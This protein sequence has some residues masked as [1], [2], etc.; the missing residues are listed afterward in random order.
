MKTHLFGSLV[1]VAGLLLTLIGGVAAQE[2]A[3]TEALPS[4]G[5]ELWKKNL[6]LGPNEWIYAEAVA[7]NGDVYIGGDVDTIA[8]MKT[9]RVAR[10]GADDQQ[11]HT[12][13]KSITWGRIYSLAISGDYLYVGGYFDAASDLDIHTNAIARWN[14]V[15]NTW[16]NVGG[17]GFSK[18]SG[19]PDVYALAVDGSGNVYAGGDFSSVNGIPAQNVAKWDGNTWSAVGSLGT[20]NEKVEALLW[21]GSTLI[22]GGN[23]ANLH[24][25][26]AWNGASWSSL[27]GGADKEVLALAA[28]SSFLY[29]GGSFS[30][31][32]NPNATTV[33]VHYIAMWTWSSG[34][35][36]LDMGG[37]FDG[38]DVDALAVGPDNMVYA[39]GRFHNSG[40]VTTSN[41][42]RWNNG[43]W[44]AVHAST[45]LAEGVY[46]N[47][48]ALTFSGQDLWI[49]GGFQTA[50]DFSTNY[51]VRWNLTDQQWFTPGG[52]TPN[53]PIY[54]VLV[55]YPYVYYGGEFNS[56]GGIRTSGVAR[57]NLLT[58]AW[59]TL[60]EGLS[61]CANFLCNG[62]VVNALAIFSS[63]LYVGGDFT[64][65]GGTAVHGLARFDLNTTTWYDVGGGVT[66]SGLF[67][68]AV[69]KSLYFAGGNLFVGGLFLKAGAVTVNNVAEWSG[70]NWSA[71]HD[72]GSGV[73][74]T[75]GF[76]Y[77][78]GMNQA[79]ANIY[80][81]GN[82][83][84]PAAKIA[85]WTGSNW[86]SVGTGT[87][88]NGAVNAVDYVGSNLFIG[89]DFTNAGGSSAN[90]LARLPGGSG[91][92]VAVGG[93]VDGPVRALADNL[94]ELVVG[95]DFTN[96]G[97]VP[98]K[99][100]V[101]WTGT[102]WKT[103][104][105]GMSGV[106]GSSHNPTVNAV[107]INGVY[108][109]LG[110]TFRTAGPFISDNIAIW[111][112]RVSYL[113]LVNR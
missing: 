21:H 26:A 50:G 10:W 59:S 52:N 47:V 85:R 35:Y 31:V 6:S 104:G 42:A 17:P 18:T 36:W 60:G 1:L 80:I 62:P 88:L 3:G 41:I 74:G 24:Y 79:N 82:F 53:G 57:Y 108:V 34:G 8:S 51:V 92:W 76:V 110:G 54:A 101:R 22:A 11:W 109:Y 15:T 86:S 96:A 46:G 112:G 58:N 28:D 84:S 29:V 43:S 23:F 68:T 7:P 70:G 55:I 48:Y 75:N 14:M 107:V 63:N 93:S 37:G 64:H 67:C 103:L 106:Q 44:E 56:A 49:G 2:D 40:S 19:S 5:D 89:G 99:H 111:G 33:C 45:S 98:A 95:G 71:L 27:G 66:C 69:V 4:G 39:G 73:T 72:N 25:I 16:S 13:G 94:S 102:L 61:G 65:A 78:I 87:A 90:Y 32:T 38:P 81:G 83:T 12:L 30:T 9:G 97:A 100:V 20:T 105:S 113:P 91:S 77:D